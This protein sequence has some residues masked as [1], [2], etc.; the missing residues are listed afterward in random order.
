MAR[1][2]ILVLAVA[3][4]PA[5]SKA[6]QESET[7]QW[8]DTQPPKNMPPPAD[9]KIGL[10]VHGSEKGSITADMLNTTK[11]DFVDAEREAWLIH[12]LVPDAAA[13][14]TTVEAVSP[15]G[16][17]IKFERPSAAG[18]EP[19]LF[20]TRRGEIIVSAIDPKDPF[21]RYHGQ[22]GRLHRAGNS[23]PQ[24]GPVARLEITRAATP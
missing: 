1:W 14:G 11:P 16:V 10:K 6:S 15:A 4:A 19:V 17:S 20:L 3:F 22:G 24:M 12:T 21:P 18:L 23:L 2:L 9:L 13:P 8:P 7:K 5:C